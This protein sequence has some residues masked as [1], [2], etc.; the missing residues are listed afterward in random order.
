MPNINLDIWARIHQR[1]LDKAEKDLNTR[2]QD[3]GRE[4]GQNLTKGIEK[5]TP[6]VRRA[7]LQVADSTAAYTREVNNLKQAKNDLAKASKAEA[8]AEKVVSDRRRDSARVGDALIHMEDSLGKSRER[9]AKLAGDVADREAK[10]DAL[11]RQHIETSKNLRDS[12]LFIREARLSG[13]FTAKEIKQAELDLIPLRQKNLDETADLARSERDLSK[14]RDDLSTANDA[15]SNDEKR[16]TEARKNLQSINKDLESSESDLKKTREQISRIDDDIVRKNDAVTRSNE[17]RA[18]SI[19]RVNEAHDE[20]NK[21]RRR[22]GGGRGGNTLGDIFTDIPGVPGGRAGAIIGTGVIT[23]LGSVA[24]AAVTASQAIALLPAA[25]TAAAAG[26]GTLMIGTQGFGDT[27]KHMGDPKKFAKDIQ[28]L[29]PAAQ[30]AALEIQHLTQGPLKEL[31]QSTQDTLFRGVAERL[32]NATGQ[33]LPSASRLTGGVSGSFNNMFGNLLGQLTSPGSM[34]MINEIVDNIVSAFQKL[35]P[36]V[37]PFTD[38]MT[39]IIQTGSSFL[40]GFSQAITNAANS[41]SNFITKAQADGSLQNFMQKGVDAAVALGKTIWD[42]GQRIFEVFG[43]KSPQQFQQNLNAAIDAAT[44]LAKAITTVSE[45]VNDLMSL[46]NRIPG[47]VNTIIAAWLGFKGLGLVSHI[48]EIASGFGKLPGA[49]E[50]GAAGIVSRFGVGGPVMI[51]LAGVLASIDAIA[52]KQQRIANANAEIALNDSRVADTKKQIAAGRAPGY[53]LDK[54]GNI[55]K[56]GPLG[57]LRQ[58]WQGIPGADANGHVDMPFGSSPSG[59]LPPYS[60]FDVPAPPPEGSAKSRRDKIR[61]TLDPNSFMPDIG[62]MPAG[63]PNAAPAPGGPPVPG[64]VPP[65]QYGT[66][67]KPYA[68]PGYG[69]VDVDQRDV[70]N[71]Q[72][73]VVQQARDVRD[74]RMD[75][76]VLEKDNLATQEELL[77]AREKVADQEHQFQD[78]QLG[79]IE[80]QQGKWKKVQSSAK[81]TQNKLSAGLDSDLGLSKGLAGLADNLVRFVGNVLTAPLQALLQRVIDA[82]PNEGSG[83]IGIMAAQGKFGP[84]W[85][86]QGIAAANGQ[87]GY[88]YPGYGTAPFG[89]PTGGGQPYGLPTGTN[90]GGY[91]SSGP[92]FPAWVH[93]VEQAF[94]VK[95]STYAGHQEGDRHEAGYAPNPNHENRGI[96]WTGPV[97]AMQRFAEYLDSIR[98]NMEQVIW[99]NPQTGQR[100][101]VAGGQDVSNTGYYASDYGG[102]QNHVHTRQSQSIPLPG[103]APQGDAPWTSDWNAMAQKEAS[104]NWQANTGNGFYGGL[105]FTQ[106]SWEAAGGT[107]Y[108]PRADQASPYEQALVAENLK[109]MQ[110][111]GAWPKTYTPGSSGPDNPAAPSPAGTPTPTLQDLIDQ[112]TGG[113]GQ[114]PI[115]KKSPQVS[116]DSGSGSAPVQPWSFPALPKGGPTKNGPHGGYGDR[117]RARQIDPGFG[118][119]IPGYGGP[120]PSVALPQPGAS[121]P[122]AVNAGKPFG[123]PA[124]TPAPSQP[125]LG[126]AVGQPSPQYAPTPQPQAQPQWQPGGNSAGGGGLLGAAAGAAAG[127]FPGGGAAAQIAMQLIQRTVKFAGEATGELINGGLQ[128]LSVSDPDGGGGTD[129]STSWLGRLAGSMASAAPA[130]PSTA[131]KAD[132]NLQQL[133]AQQGQQGQPGQD[134]QQ[135]RQGNAPLIGT[136]NV[137]ADKATGQSM[138]N[139]F[140]YASAVA[141]VG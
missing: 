12:E 109:R 126:G 22:G 140:A 96:D 114:G 37:A 110:G 20:D 97:D 135:G 133:Q 95:A 58:A 69:Y 99:Q 124:A 71:A 118:V 107:Q 4:A 81:D 34:K 64:A 98:G 3:M 92:Q 44:G 131:G 94:G 50:K 138:A 63:M 141:G 82:N 137:Q 65:L 13:L 123:S 111:P 8:D 84:Q 10:H 30:Q 52:E 35:E 59:V 36:A 42:I 139:E 9:S 122:W 11:R 23:V 51:A 46:I 120:A 130:L 88:G 136:M 28:S 93:A 26:I 21:R 48:G 70:W 32:H 31:Q 45:F 103:F 108:A 78:A 121:N 73:K 55:V 80:A 90:T 101:G 68:K 116:A 85:T 77:K 15:V 72:Y 14:A 100:I 87:T 16:I 79:L 33:L 53:S 38:A 39:K 60:P 134:P 119:G 102:H 127:M 5:E 56:S 29:S 75:L 43:N 2:F 54:D 62:N 7:M 113:G 117:A 49:A 17:K 125:G 40:P 66:N 47:G 129:W 27:L 1:S 76:A 115:F 41:F 86:P 112:F 106:S 24:E 67:G 91:G 132:K 61:G 83:L 89:T 74:A 18:E 57:G 19:R 104:G 128:A 6:R 25:A 105:Q